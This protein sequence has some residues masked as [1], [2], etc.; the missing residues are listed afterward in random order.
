MKDL[1]SNQADQY[2]KFRPHYPKAM[3]DYFASLCPDQQLAW[4]CGTGN[5]QAASQLAEVFKDVIAT[6]PSE[7]QLANA[8][9]KRNIEYRVGRE[10]TLLPNQS[11]SLVTV[12]Q[13]LHWFDHPRF[14]NEVK[15][16]LKPKGVIAV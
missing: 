14:Y 5:G 8:P 10:T 9:C 15:R 7:K 1:F 13:A 2:S 3:F 6:D 12:A 16:V 11:V 4:D